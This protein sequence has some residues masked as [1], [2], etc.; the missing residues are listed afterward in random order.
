MVNATSGSGSYSYSWNTNPVQTNAI[1][2]DLPQG[3][4]TITVSATDACPASA[5]VIIPV[6]LSCIGVYFPSAFT[7]NGD[8]RN[9]FFG[10]SGSL[11]SLSNY[12][13]SIYNRWG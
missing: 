4:Y 10:P 8:G 3:T 7:P 5:N 2:N 12:H 1:A 6:D 13:I 9:D 11:S